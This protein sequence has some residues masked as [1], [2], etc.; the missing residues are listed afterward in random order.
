[1][2]ICRQAAPGILRACHGGKY[3]QR[4]LCAMAEFP[5]LPLFTDA[6]LA[7]TRHLTAEEHGA[8]LLLLMCAWR[9]R[10]CALKDCDRTL[11]RIVGVT[12]PRW[13]RLRPVLAEFFTVKDGVWRQKKLTEVYKG[14]EARVAKNRAN[15]ARG[16]RVRAARAAKAAHAVP[17]IG[18]GGSECLSDRQSDPLS[19]GGS[20]SVPAK[21]Q[22]P[23]PQ[24]EPEAEA[25]AAL[26]AA[27]GLGVTRV[28]GAVLA[29]WLAAGADIG[30]D[31][32][33]TVQRLRLREEGKTGRAPA[34][35]AYYGAA[36]M[37]A[38]DSRV[39]AVQAGRA[40]AEARPPAPAK[41]VFDAGSADDWRT[42]LGDATSRF[43]GDYLSANWIIGR[44][45]P[46]FEATTLGPDPR[47]GINRRIPEEVMNEYAAGWGWRR[48]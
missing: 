21:S 18:E 37:E 4:G 13:K 2:E 40:H 35:L 11:A 15:G 30:L 32:V 16:G 44:D 7:D 8:Y 12:R 48:P 46:V 5:A 26:A 28:K 17:D 34:S 10:G 41:R 27:A 1:M 3:G 33:P 31:I 19:D 38:R 9:T 45:H 43:R 6:Y 25:L 24:P 14:V 42:F 22:N 29:G 39:G 20:E 23:E 47:C 36:V